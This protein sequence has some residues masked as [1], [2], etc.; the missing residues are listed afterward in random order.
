MILEYISV[1]AD[2]AIIFL[3]A[4][5]SYVLWVLKKPILETAQNSEAYKKMFSK[6]DKTFSKKVPSQIKNSGFPNCQKWDDRG[7]IHT[8]ECR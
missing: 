4:V 8:E 1:S 5:Q 7:H 6:I 2:L 3:L